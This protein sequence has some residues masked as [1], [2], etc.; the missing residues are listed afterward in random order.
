MGSEKIINYCCIAM[1]KYR[2][3]TLGCKV[4][5]FESEAIIEFLNESDWTP[6]EKYEEADV[7]IINTCTVT[8]KASMQS[9]QAIRQAIKTNPNARIIVTGC[10]AQTGSEEIKEI[11]GVH[12]IIGHSLKHRIPNSVISSNNSHLPDSP[13][14]IIRDIN[15]ELFFKQTPI[16]AAG[17]RTRPFLKIQD[18]CNASC[19]YCIVP[20][21]RG[22]SRSMPSED[23]LERIDALKYAGYRETVLTGIHLG[24]YGQDLS[25]ENGLLSDLVEGIVAA[26]AMDRIRLS[27]IEPNELTTDIIKQVAHSDCLCRHFHIPLQSGSDKILKKM[28]RPYSTSS[29]RDLMFTICK[30][31][32]DAAIGCDILV[33]FPGESEEDFEN[34]YL[35]IEGLP[36]TYL[37]VFPFSP[38]KGT[39]A[40]D[41]PNQVSPDIIKERCTKI[42]KLGILKKKMFYE[43]SLG[44]IKKVLVEGKRDRDTG[45]LK[46]LTSNYI[47]VLIDGPDYLKNIIVKTEIE[48]IHNNDSVIGKVVV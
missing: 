4:N 20:Y 38:R 27:S 19:T 48:K 47:S 22:P 43:K 25:P 12:D 9:R 45:F 33:G 36:V 3:T 18:G 26:N 11:E 44:K 13:K 42:R 6:I 40:Y 7:C 35:L 15:K 21:T 23:V 34:T 1:Q 2:V 29:F 5:Q 8:Q 10:Y 16:M 46:G 31:I 41:Y 32:P 28:K 30:A 39:K 14:T 17:N 24:A 37:H